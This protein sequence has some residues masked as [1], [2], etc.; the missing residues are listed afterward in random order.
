M[1][2]T[3]MRKE[4]LL[5]TVALMAGIGLASAQGLREGGSAGGSEHGMSSGSSHMSPGSGAQGGSETRGEGAA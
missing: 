4:L 2:R 1:T 3:K 5:G